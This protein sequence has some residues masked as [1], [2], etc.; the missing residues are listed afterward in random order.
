MGY[1]IDEARLARVLAEGVQCVV[2]V[3][4][5]N[6]LDRLEKALVEANRTLERVRE[7]TRS[8]KKLLALRIAQNLASDD[9]GKGE[10]CLRRSLND[11]EVDHVSGAPVL[12]FKHDVIDRITKALEGRDAKGRLYE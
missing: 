2:P 7:E 3:E 9:A 4:V 10:S 5:K 12:A 11:Y 1:Y 8:E 6:E